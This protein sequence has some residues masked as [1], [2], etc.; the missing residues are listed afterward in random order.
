VDDFDLL[1]VIGFEYLQSL[2]PPL[3]VQVFGKCPPL[4]GPTHSYFV[5]IVRVPFTCPFS[6]G[7][8]VMLAIAWLLF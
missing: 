2:A 3:C 7:L 8:H 5:V 1:Q 4:V 6:V